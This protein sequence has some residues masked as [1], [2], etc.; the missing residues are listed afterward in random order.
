[1]PRSIV[2]LIVVLVVLVA[3]AIFLAGRGTVKEPTRMEKV[4]PLENLAK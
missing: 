1:M 4:V 2:A 3:G